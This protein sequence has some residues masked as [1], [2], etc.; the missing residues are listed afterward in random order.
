MSRPAVFLDT[1]IL[2]YAFSLG[3]PRSEPAERLLSTGAILSVQTLNEFIA[4]AQRKLRWS[5]PDI[6]D[7]LDV[8]REFCPAIAPLSLDTHG[9]ALLIAQ[10]FGYGIYDAMVIASALESGCRTLYSEDMKNGQRI[11]G[12]TICNPFAS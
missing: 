1:H 8:I 9:K 11:E 12:L 7:A 6:V 4:V 2:V 5:W 3:D 10:R